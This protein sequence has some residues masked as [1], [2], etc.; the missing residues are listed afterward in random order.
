MRNGCRT[1]GRIA[2]LVLAVLALAVPVARAD[3]IAYTCESDLCL[4]NPDNPAEHRY[5]TET[6]DAIA[7]ERSPSWSSDG[8]RIAYNGHLGNWDVWTLD[9]TKTAAEVIATN[10]SD[11]PDRSVESWIQP[12]WSPDGTMLAYAERYH[13]NAPPNLESEVYVSPADGT[14]NPLAIGSTSG[15]SELSPAWSPD[16]L[17]LVFSRQGSLWVGPPTDSVEPTNLLNSYG[18]KP[19]FSP[20][21]T[22]VATVTFSSPEHLRV[23][24]ADGSGIKE[25]PVPA[26][27]GSSVDWSP[28]STQIVYSAD[29]EP[30][31]RIRVA[32]ADGSGPGHAIEMPAGWVVPYHAV[33][34]PDGTRIAFDAYPAGGAGYRQILIA[35]A[36]GSSPAVPITKSAEQNEEPDWKPCEGCAPPVKPQAPGTGGASGDGQ[37]TKTPTTVRLI[38]LKKVYAWK[39]M[40]PVFVDCN[41]QGG[42]PDPKYCNGDGIA[43][44]VAPRTAF[45]PWAKPKPN[46][47]IVFAKGSVKVPEGKSKP[48]KLKLTA[49]GKKLLSKGKAV[50]VKLSVK[51]TRPNGKALTFKKTISVQP[52]PPKGK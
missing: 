48:L 5:L 15:K 27:L 52:K 8:S 25:L 17:T 45:R 10:I 30:L 46:K 29:E 50:Q 36:D 20:D 37:P 9:P 2:G 39:Y 6:D 44:A 43:K 18:Y 19:A 24:N 31:D 23:T 41:A 35:P 47:P 16:G 13:S 22:R 4:I 11:S 12:A 38:Y 51:V 1:V 28:D 33:F 42:H 49:A 34:S 14:A 7:S 3:Q 32:P 26:E 40:T 21:G